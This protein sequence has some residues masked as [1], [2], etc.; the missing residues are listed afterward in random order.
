MKLGKRAALSPCWVFKRTLECVLYVSKPSTRQNQ[1]QK[2][3]MTIFSPR[4][5]G[6]FLRPAMGSGSSQLRLAPTIAA[7]GHP[8]PELQ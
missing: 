7:N 4:A 2:C 8:Q 6:V 5:G 3:P 1:Q